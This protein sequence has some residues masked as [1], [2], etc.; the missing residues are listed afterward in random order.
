ML[1]LIISGGSGTR[2]WPISRKQMPK[3]FYPLIEKESLFEKTVK[4]NAQFCNEILVITNEV[5]YLLAKK[6]LPKNVSIDFMLEPIGRDTAPAIALG[7]MSVETETIVLVTPADHLIE[8][9]KNYQLVLEQAKTFAQ[10]DNLVTLGIQPKYPETGFGY[11][12]SQ[13]NDVLSFKEK[14]DLETA[15]QYLS[16]GNYYWNSGMFCF[17]AGVFLAELEKYAPE[18]FIACQKTFEKTPQN[19]PYKLPIQEMQNIP[20]ISI[21][22]GV[23]EKSELVKVVPADIDWSDLGSFDALYDYLPKTEMGNSINP[24][25]FNIE[26]KNNLILGDKRLISTIDI[27]NLLIVDSPDALLICN[28]N[29]SQKVKPI[30]ES[31]KKQKSTLVEKHLKSATK[32]GT[33][34]NTAE[35]ENY[36]IESLEIDSGIEKVDFTSEAKSI[37][38]SVIEGK[39]RVG[40]DVVNQNQQVQINEKNYSIWILSSEKTKL[41]QTIIY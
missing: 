8:N 13:G 9:E 28:R 39:I 1:N 27:E 19:K 12:E 7:C 37:H 4:R 20:S 6:Q 24:N 35:S 3:Q 26:S 41:I 21:D 34:E 2:M 38:V 14:P 18:I 31:L 40:D 17:K 10:A 15:K 22:Y 36:K 11:I 32:W 16:A 30:V 23:M 29:A 25:H 5:H 33:I